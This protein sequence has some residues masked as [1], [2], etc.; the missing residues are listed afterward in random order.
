MR[1]V[2]YEC[3]FLESALAIWKCIDSVFCVQYV[4]SILHRAFAI[5][6]SIAIRVLRRRVIVP[7]FWSMKLSYSMTESL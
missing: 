7:F 3:P 2:L 4:E 1:G 5:L 6:P